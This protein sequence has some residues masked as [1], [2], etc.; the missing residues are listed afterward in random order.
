MF[1][2]KVM[3]AA[4]C[5]AALSMSAVILSAGEIAFKDGMKVSF[6]GDSITQ[7]GAGPFGYVTL[8]AKGLEANGIKIQA[9]GAGVSGHKSNQMLARLEKD[10][11]SKQPDM[12]TLSCGVNDVW[13]GARGVSLEDYKKNITDIVD[14]AQAANIKVVILTATMIKEDANNEENKKLVA[15]NEFLKYLATEKKCILAD[16]NADMQNALKEMPGTGN[17][18]TSD[19]VHMNPYGN[20]MMASGILKACGLSD[21]QIA[22]AKASWEKMPG[23][24]STKINLSIEE[25]N[26]LK[27]K[28]DAEKLSV[29]AYV[30]NVCQKALFPESAK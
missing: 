17:K 18:L 13:H 26:G 6:L 27:K 14:K 15:Y 1:F 12:M 19:G 23:A 16:L 22:K 29:D 24:F 2:R 7:Q 8:V 5:A 4:L 10:V 21:E 20:M 25:Y 3:S 9:M 30:G 11:I 28:A